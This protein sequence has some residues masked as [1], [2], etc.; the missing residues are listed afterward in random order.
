MKIRNWK[1]TPAVFANFILLSFIIGVLFSPFSGRLKNAADFVF[2]QEENPLLKSKAIGSAIDIQEALR[3]IYKANASS[4]VRIE[5]EQVVKMQMN[6]FFNDPVFRKYFGAP[7]EREQKRQG[8]GSGFI[9]SKDGYIVTNNHV[10]SNVDKITV[11]VHGGKSYSAKIIGSDQVA[12]IAL[13]K[14][15]GERNLKPVYLGDSDDIRVGDFSIAIGNPFGL[16]STFTFGVIS[17]TG[18]DIDAADGINR[19]Q[20]DAAINPGNSGGP[21]LN[22]KGEVIGINQ[23]IYSQSGGSVGIGF[24]IPINHVKVVVENLKTGKKIK[25]GYIGVSIV[26]PNDPGMERMAKELGIQNMKGL[27]VRDVSF[28]SPAMKAGLR[29]YDYIIEVDGAAADK[30]SVLKATVMR[31]GVGAVIDVK[32]IRGGKTETTKIKI[33]ELPAREQEQQ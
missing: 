30:F 24:A 21:L 1:I 17:S 23:M 13:L 26:D 27:L 32:Y 8:L 9:I 20:T 4:V 5:T 31:K 16:E 12:D 10:V 3:E 29:Q 11:K 33:E 7:Q 28:E 22:I 25:P 14:I 18:Q 2:A 6:P 15:E 19:I